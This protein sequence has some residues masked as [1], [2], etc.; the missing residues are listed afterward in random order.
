MLVPM[1]LAS[2]FIDDYQARVH[3]IQETIIAREK[4]PANILT[5]TTKQMTLLK[6]RT[7]AKIRTVP[8]KQTNN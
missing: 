7:Q 5:K 3:E 6:M 8:T 4:R 2:L 1:I